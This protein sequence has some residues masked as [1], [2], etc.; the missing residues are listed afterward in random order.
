MQRLVATKKMMWQCIINRTVEST[1]SSFIITT[2][3]Y[4]DQ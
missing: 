3:H 1:L 2:W 4:V